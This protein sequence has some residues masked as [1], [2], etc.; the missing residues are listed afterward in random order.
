MDYRVCY[1][2]RKSGAIGVFY[3]KHVNVCC[4]TP[5]DAVRVAFDSLHNQ[6]YETRNPLGL[7]QLGPMCICGS[8]E[9][10]DTNPDTPE[11]WCPIHGLFP[12][13]E[14][15]PKR[16]EWPKGVDCE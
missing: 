7:W 11:S 13:P 16:I 4:A 10:T 15:P 9:P 8:W 6:G 1:E 5:E 14:Q 3:S 12:V 2:A